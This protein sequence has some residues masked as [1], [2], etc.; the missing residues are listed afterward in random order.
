MDSAHTLVS[1]MRGRSPIRP[2]R[3]GGDAEMSVAPIGRET[4]KQ[5]EFPPCVFKLVTKHLAP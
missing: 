3:R 4:G 2:G 5:E 1:G